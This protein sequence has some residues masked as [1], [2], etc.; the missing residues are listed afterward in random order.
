M[1]GAWGFLA[2]RCCLPFALARVGEFP[3]VAGPARLMLGSLV[4]VFLGLAFPLVGVCPPVCLGRFGLGCRVPAGSP[5]GRPSRGA[6][7]PP[8]RGSLR[9]L[10]RSL[11]LSCS[12]GGASLPAVG[13]LASPSAPLVRQS[14]FAPCGRLFCPAFAGFLSFRFS[15]LRCGCALSARAGNPRCGSCALGLR[16][17][18]P[19]LGGSAPPLGGFLFRSGV[20]VRPFPLPAT[21]GQSR[22]LARCAPFPLINDSVVRRF[23]LYGLGAAAPLLVR[24]ASRLCWICGCRVPDTRA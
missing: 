21:R 23:F 1:A 22:P 8:L 9:A 15:S 20:L 11:P 19:H 18:S 4:A 5:A 12:V 16:P 13:S 7:R 10:P 17:L 14:G 2:A 6:G 3:K 24:A